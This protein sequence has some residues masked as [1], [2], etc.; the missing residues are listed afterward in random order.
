MKIDILDF[1]T[2][3]QIFEYRKKA[4]NFLYS[5]TNPEYTT[6]FLGLSRSEILE[7]K[8]NEIKEI[9]RDACLNIIAS[10]EARFMEDFKFRVKRNRSNN[11]FR[12]I[13]PFASKPDR[14]PIDHIIDAWKVQEIIASGILSRFKGAYKYRNWLAHGRHWAKPQEHDFW[15]LYTIAISTRLLPLN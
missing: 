9:E 10:V 13:L 5:E 3:A 15:D 14:I 2:I 12:N 11:I 8:K 4:L 1:D 7:Q 6:L